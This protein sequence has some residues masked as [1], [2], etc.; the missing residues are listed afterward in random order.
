MAQAFSA[1]G[2]AVTVLARSGRLLPR[3]HPKAGEAVAAALREAGVAVRYNATVERVAHTY[4]EAGGFPRITLHA[5]EGGGGGE[6]AG[7]CDG[8]GEEGWALE[9]DALLV[10]TGREPNTGDL[11]LDAAGVE[12]GEG[13][14]LVDELLAT[15]NPDVYAAGD[16]VS[17]TPRLTHVA[18]E[19]AKVAVENALFGGA[20]RHTSLVVPSVIYTEPEVAM[21]GMSLAAARAAGVEVEE[22]SSAL[23]GNDR[24]ILEGE[25]E[26]GG[27]VS[28]LCRRGGDEIVG[29]TVVG[30]RAGEAINELTLA[31][32][33]KVGLAAVAR[34]IHPYPTTGEAVMQAALGFVRA[35]W[36]TMPNEDERDS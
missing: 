33:A 34:S 13:G 20:W 14:I 31:I 8:G 15:S 6:A 22:Y 32:H 16:V 26:E 5:V 35:R 21:V 24:A 9:C 29:A 11:G 12:T 23:A 18:G 28:I 10:A 27:F 25:D 7:E 36:A 17:G 4:P 19:H 30:S 2:S 3:E 1:F